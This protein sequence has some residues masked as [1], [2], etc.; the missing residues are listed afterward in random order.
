MDNQSG[1]SLTDLTEKVL[2]EVSS[3]I[4]TLSR[5][6]KFDL[7]TASKTYR[8]ISM[9]KLT[10]QGKIQQ[11]TRAS[12]GRSFASRIGKAEFS[13]VRKATIK[14][15]DGNDKQQLSQKNNALMYEVY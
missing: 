10:S 14:D 15:K 6:S 1:T 13:N 3:Y 8:D 2:E 12:I 7:N 11:A 4:S 5:G 9:A